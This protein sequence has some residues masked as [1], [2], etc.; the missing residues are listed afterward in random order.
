MP[1][2]CSYIRYAH[3]QRVA[4]SLRWSAKWLLIW[5][6]KENQTLHRIIILRHIFWF[7]PVYISLKCDAT[8]I[9]SNLIVKEFIFIDIMVP[10][11]SRQLCFVWVFIFSTFALLPIGHNPK[12]FVPRNFCTFFILLRILN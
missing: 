4:I 9:R 10:E 12:I 7:S 3:I 1:Q 2:S 6:C 11:L 5:L 8:E